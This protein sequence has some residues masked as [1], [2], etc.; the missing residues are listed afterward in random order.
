M[1]KVKSRNSA[2]YDGCILPIPL[3]TNS[4]YFHADRWVGDNQGGKNGELGNLL[5]WK[6]CI[7]EGNFAFWREIC[8]ILRDDWSFGGQKY[9]KT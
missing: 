2:N 3:F 8:A 4:H 5:P 9:I 1:R 6:S 7:L